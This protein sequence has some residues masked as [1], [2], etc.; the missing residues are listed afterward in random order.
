M[1]ETRCTLLFL[2]K[3]DHILLAMKKRGFGVG[4]LN[5][6]GGKL[7]PNEPLEQALQR[8][9]EEEIN[10]Q[11]LSYN[12]VAE[13]K[14]YGHND[15]FHMHVFVYLSDKWQGEPTETEEMAPAWHPTDAIPYDQ[16]WSDDILWLPKILEN[17]KIYG[18]FYFDDADKVISHT[19]REV[20]SLPLEE[21]V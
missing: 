18:E 3:D 11:P 8:E 4:R 5:G 7:K 16:M 21:N 17:K 15:S 1:T 10:V 14:F 19:L 9:C 12:L 6:V 20:G 2:R 13:H